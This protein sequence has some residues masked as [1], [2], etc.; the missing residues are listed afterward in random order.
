MRGTNP[1]RRPYLK[2]SQAVK[3]NLMRVSL[4]FE[5]I[6]GGLGEQIP[7]DTHTWKIHKGWKGRTYIDAH[8][9][10]IFLIGGETQ[11]G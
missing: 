9:Y 3:G 11:R 5:N 2:N 1:Y 6:L 10:K 8:T 7:I 4:Y